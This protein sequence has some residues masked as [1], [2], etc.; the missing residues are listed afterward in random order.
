[1]KT[2][3][4][5]TING[6]S[7]TIGLTSIKIKIFETEKEVNVYIVDGEKFKYDFLI[8]LD[9][10]KDFRL[11][12][13]NQLKISQKIEINKSEEKQNNYTD[14]D[15][16]RL[17]T[18]GIQNNDYKKT[19]SESSYGEDRQV[20]FNEY[21]IEE[22]FKMKINHLNYY[23]KLEI[24]KLIECNK[25]V[26]AK[27]KYDIGTVNGYEA[28]IDLLIDKYCSKRPYRCSLEDRVE[29]EN[30][31]SNLLEN[32]LIE[33]SYSPFAAPVTLAFKKEDQRKSRLCIDFRDLNKLVV[34]QAQPFPLIEDLM[35]KARDCKY[36]STLDINSAFWS[37][38]LRIEDKKKTGFVT[39]SGHYQWTCLPFGLKTS[40][41]IFQRILSSILRKYKLTNFAV[42]YIDDILIFS[43]T[44]EEHTQHL[45]QLLEAIKKEGFRLKFTKCAFAEQMVQ[46]LG[47]IIAN[48]TIKPIKNNIKSIKEF[49]LPKTQKNIRQFLGKINFYHNYIPESAVILEPLHNLLRK[50]Q[51]F[52][53]DEN[54]QTAFDKVKDILCS[55][56][57]LEIFDYNLP[58]NIYTD[59]SIEG[60]G[61]ILKQ[62][63]STGEEKPV[64]YFSKKL[65]EVQKRKK[66]I[67]LESLAIKEAIRY[68]QYWLI[69]RPF[70]VYCDHKPLENMN[71]KSRTDED[72]GD[73]IYYLSQYD[74]KIIYNPG[75]LNVEADCLSRNPVLEADENSEEQLKIVNLIKIEDVIT[76]QNNNEDISN[77]QNKLIKKHNVFFKKIR[78][79]EKI[80]LSEEF[81]IKFIKNVHENLC[82]IGIEQMQKMLSPHYTTKNLTKNI[83]KTCKGCEIC[84]K[85]KSR[86]QN[87]YG[88][89]SHLGPPTKPFEIVSIDT[90]GGFG[91]SRST[92]K[93]LHL[94]VDHFSRYAFIVT[95]KT[96][97][98]PDF[99]K[100]VSNITETDNIGMVL[101]DQYPGINSNEFKLFLEEKSIPIVL[102]AVNTPF[103]NG[104][105]ERLNQTLVNKIRCSI[106]EKNNNKKAWTT[107]AQDCV[108]KYNRTEHTVT[109]F[110]PE[111]LLYGTDVTI[112][113]NELKGEKLRT[114]WDKDKQKA[115]QNSITSHNYNKKL[116]DHNRINLKINVGDLVYVENG[117]KLNRKKLD[118]LR[119]GPY[120]I[121]E[122]IS[123][124]IYKIE[125]GHKKSASN[126][127]H[128][129]KLIPV[130]TEKAEEEDADE[131]LM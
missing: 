51:K 59:A 104:L 119:I 123:E 100:L 23:E 53:W 67:Y 114:N 45:S 47:H 28:R 121:L 35:I 117:N 130:V 27:D 24:E 61:A 49:P 128:I 65:N 102:T 6:V 72:L 20:N 15:I 75:K 106:N 103:S 79:K 68:W 57:V 11:I 7:K 8:G 30:Q 39:Q 4:L 63:Q 107:I 86:G 78:K 26:F 54:C 58:I 66:A 98:A 116:F 126:F 13:D 29:I 17:K 25:T 127:F 48:N 38:P 95:S 89:L 69:G 113:P 41:A 60:I 43:R 3:N 77:N 70:T 9:I 82:H 10:I 124:S 22:N 99:I 34:P 112:L 131:I 88:L 50:N 83:K 14:P 94:L 2:D 21:I 71:I 84:I 115:V 129:S 36:F 91:G 80:I 42:N 73:L 64:A 97:S 56:P 16:L 44:F 93:Y 87:K 12:Q 46:Y 32:K 31:V 111:Y 52:I 85:N 109:K 81:S 18:P 19:D 110:A 105:N 122:K 33:E 90:I 76:D 101:A 40:P 108:K 1:M 125:T 92:K 62:V 55:Q 74:F 120:K 118:E 37:I 5:V 96:Q